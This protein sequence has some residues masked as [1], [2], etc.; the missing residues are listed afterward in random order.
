MPS[1]INKN[2]DHCSQ[3]LISIMSCTWKFKIL[4]FK[5]KHTTHKGWDGGK[6][7]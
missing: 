3:G 4:I 2:S 6:R 7:P 5:I 1:I